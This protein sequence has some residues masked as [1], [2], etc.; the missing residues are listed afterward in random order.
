MKTTAVY[1][2]NQTLFSN[3]WLENIIKDTRRGILSIKALDPIFT[4]EEWEQQTQDLI[5]NAQLT[6]MDSDSCEETYSAESQF[7][8]GISG[9]VNLRNQL[10]Y[11]FELALWCDEKE[12]ELYDWDSMDQQLE[13]CW[14]LIQGAVSKIPPVATVH[15][16][17][18]VDGVIKDIIDTYKDP[19]TAGLPWK[20]PVSWGKDSSSVVQL[21]LEALFRIPKSE[22]NRPIYLVTADTR[23]ELPP[24]LQVMRKNLA[25]ITN[26]IDRHDLPI[27][28]KVV[29]PNLGER[30]FTNLI[31]K[32]YTPPLGGPVKRWC[33]SRLKLQPQARLDK[34]LGESVAVLGTRYGESASRAKSMKKYSGESRYGY[35]TIPG[36]ISYAPIAYLTLKQVWNVLKNGFWWGDNYS[37]LFNLY[38]AS[39]FEEQYDTV[40]ESVS[41]RMGCAVCFVVKRDRALENLIQNGYEWLKPLHDYRNFV[42]TIV[43]NPVYREP[44]PIDRRTALPT[45]RKAKNPVKKIGGINQKGRQLLLDRLLETQ[46]MLIN[47]MKK[48]NFI[49]E[50]G[51]ELI[52][53]EEVHWIKSWWNHLSGYNEPGFIPSEVVSKQPEN[54]LSLF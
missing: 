35:T 31:G 28:V 1:S 49:I 19:A 41:A 25:D 44:V 7:D 22:R 18:C 26:F 13:H 40:H 23:L 42:L 6:L 4:P 33:T 8:I 11:W 53:A 34:E 30:F 39:S 37:M 17:T 32:G 43:E 9:L 50:G 14:S 21:V 2:T 15:N 45:T 38:Q 24:M 51:Y 29:E 27:T 3:E 5:Q 12:L 48:A 16:L 54:Q 47:G 46:E 36:V 20:L 10:G 52:T